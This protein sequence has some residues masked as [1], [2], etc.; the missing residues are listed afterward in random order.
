MFISTDFLATKYGVHDTIANFFVEREPPE[1]NLY[2]K[3]K[4]LYLRPEPGFLFIPIM[5]DALNK[6]GIAREVLLSDKYINLVEQIG[7]IAALEETA[8]INYEQAI[9][10]CIALTKQDAKNKN[11]YA[12]LTDY[13][14]GGTNHFFQ[15]LLLPFSAL[16]RG[17]IFLFSVT[18]LD[19][20][21]EKAKEIVKYWFAIIGSFL[22][23]DDANDLESDKKTG[24]LNSFLQSG[25]DKDGIEQ[26]KNLLGDMLATLKTFNKPLARAIDNQFVKM[27]ELPHIQQYLNY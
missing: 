11:F 19:F 18:I 25:L 4:L 13:M 10:Q 17:D 14:Q 7:H 21:D 16:H 23:L 6:L 9:E 15:L 22:M 24:E 27:A 1:N 5:V 12:S 26:I 3:D 8:Q 20:D 2:W